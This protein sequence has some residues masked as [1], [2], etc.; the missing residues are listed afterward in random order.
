MCRRLLRGSM[1]SSNAPEIIAAFNSRAHLVD[2]GAG[3]GD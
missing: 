1:L 2:K 3:C